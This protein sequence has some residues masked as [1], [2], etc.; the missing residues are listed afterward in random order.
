MRGEASAVNRQTLHLV[1]LFCFCLFNQEV[2]DGMRV[3]FTPTAL[4]VVGACAVR[5]TF[6]GAAG[7]AR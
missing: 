1:S 5:Q 6:V 3:A 7:C 2:V 4:C